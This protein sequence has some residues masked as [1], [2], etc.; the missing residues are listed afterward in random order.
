MDQH[1]Y[2]IYD[3]TRSEIGEL[4]YQLKY[5]NDLSASHR[6]VQAASTFLK[7]SRSKFDVIVPVPPSGHRQ[8]QPVGVLAHGIGRELNLP[9]VDCVTT[10]RAPTPLKGV[11]FADERRELMQGLYAVN[12]DSTAGKSILLFDDLYRSGTT[13]NTITEL[14]MNE[15]CAQ[16]VRVLTITK[17]RSNR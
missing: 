15:G 16:A 12:T 5:R 11:Q 9:V 10:R 8:V 6:I 4:L 13:L 17:T 7:R 2:D 1:G 3:T 14:L